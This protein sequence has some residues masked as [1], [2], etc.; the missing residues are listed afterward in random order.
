MKKTKSKLQRYQHTTQ[1]SSLQTSN[2]S[3][4]RS[5]K[6]HPIEC[7]TWVALN[8]HQVERTSEKKANVLAVHV[9]SAVFLLSRTFTICMW[10]T[11]EKA[12][13]ANHPPCIDRIKM[14]KRMKWEIKKLINFLWAELFFIVR[15]FSYVFGG[16]RIADETGRFAHESTVRSFL[17]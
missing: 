9:E 4:C 15:N 14:R 6:S 17:I 12:T 10:E 8:V 5:K 3:F 16:W 13:Q 7:V 11:R 1:N 2:H